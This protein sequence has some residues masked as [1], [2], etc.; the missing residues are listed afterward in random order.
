MN[1]GQLSRVIKSEYL[2]DA[3]SHTK[4]QGQPFK[5]AEIE[6]A[7]NDAISNNGQEA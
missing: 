4:I 1:L 5:V 6:S 2:I 7:I 3:I